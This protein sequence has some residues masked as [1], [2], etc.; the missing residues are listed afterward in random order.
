[1]SIESQGSS[2]KNSKNLSDLVA[3]NR[4][5]PIL[6]FTLTASFFSLAGIPPFIGFY[7]KFTIFLVSVE[8][9]IYIIVILSLLL[10]IISPFYYIII[11]K[12]IY[13]EN[14][15]NWNFYY[16]INKEKSIK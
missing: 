15:I 13:F 7:A 6:A 14:T 9:S 4:S 3:L 11:I 1:L 10:S 12:I 16:P 5:N 8:L 2:L